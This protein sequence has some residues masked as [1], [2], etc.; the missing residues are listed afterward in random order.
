[1]NPAPGADLPFS[2][3]AERNRQPI[4]EVLQTLLPEQARVLEI[5]AGTGQ[6]AAHFAAAQPGWQWQPTDARPD[7]LPGIAARCEGLANVRPPR[8]LDVMRE[9]WPSLAG[10]FDAVYAAN[11]LHVSPPPALAALMRGAFGQLRPGGRLVLYGPFIVD[12]EP[13]AESN[14]AFDADLKAR[15]PQWGL[16]RLA[17]V[18]RAAEDAGLVFE[19]RIDRPANNM[20]VSFRRPA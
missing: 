16:R 15:D 12:G 5:A 20:M 7:A 13:V 8:V 3:A 17:L 6:H 19:Q 14:L 9:P 11:L 18:Q 1:M 4:L 2:P 10:P